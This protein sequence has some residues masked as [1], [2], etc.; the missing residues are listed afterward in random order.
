MQPAQFEALHLLGVA[1]CHE[2][3]HAEG[4]WFIQQA[5]EL[6]PDDPVA[7]FNLGMAMG[8]LGRNKEAIALLERCL[9]SQPD[10]AELC[11][12]HGNML[13]KEGRLQD[14]IA[15]YERALALSPHMPGALANLGAARSAA[16]D[17][18]AA[19]RNFQASLALAPGADTHTRLSQALR[20]LGKHREAEEQARAAVALRPNHVDAW[21][22]LGNSLL[23]QQ[24]RDAAIEAY[25]A[26]LALCPDDANAHTNLGMALLAGGDFPAGFREYEWRLR[27]RQFSGASPYADRPRWRGERTD[28]VLLVHAEQGLGDTLQFCRYA[29][30]ARSRAAHVLLDVPRPLRRLLRSL[31]QVEVLD[32][33]SGAFDLQCPMMSLPHV[34]GATLDTI[35]AATPYLRA[36]CVQSA[37]WAARLPRKPRIGLVWA[38]ASSPGNPAQVAVDRRRSIAPERLAPLLETPELAFISLQKTGPAAPAAF[39]LIDPMA[40]ME[41][42]ADTAALIEN[43]DLVIA[44]DTAVAHLAAALGRPVWLLDRFDSCWRWLMGRED[45]PWY[46]G[47]RIYRQ[48]RPGDWD[49]VINRVAAD[50]SGFAMMSAA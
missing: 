1:K 20:S 43:L 42:L 24:R 45:S 8:E 30:L 11:F 33:P 32:G 17:F 46:P 2:G 34:L 16:G 3:H 31:P 41:D 5:L 27:T 4:V 36:D 7:L 9:R 15:S 48:A 6:R 50:L 22:S 25:D 14:A 44:V 18:G 21:I 23:N 38:G 49:D 10:N 26:A 40:E 29:P 13:Q 19:V 39:S 28:R 37:A 47:L 35:P 12:N